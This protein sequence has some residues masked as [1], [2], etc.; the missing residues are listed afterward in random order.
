MRAGHKPLRRVVADNIRRL[1]KSRSLTQEALAEEAG[2]HRTFIGH[3]E[4]ARSNISVDNLER[5]AQALDVSAAE[6]VAEVAEGR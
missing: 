5:L 6:L 1:R 3:V 4:R 2:L